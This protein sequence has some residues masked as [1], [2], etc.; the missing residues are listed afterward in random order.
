MIQSWSSVAFV[1]WRV[2]PDLIRPLVPSAFEVD[3]W[4]GSAWVGLVPFRMMTRAPFLPPVPV[5]SWFPETNVRT[6]VRDGLGRRGVWFLS[7]D[8]PRSAMVAVA[9]SALGL[10]YAWSRMSIEENELGAT[11][12]LARIA[13]NVGA[14]S[15]VI[16]PSRPSRPD[17]TALARFLTARFRLFGTGPLGPYLIPIEHRPWQLRRLPTATIEDELVGLTG[18]PRLGEPD[19]I[20]TSAGVHVRVGF[21]RLLE[22]SAVVAEADP[23]SPPT[24]V[25][26]AGVGSA[27]QVP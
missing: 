5:L 21:P 13:P 15:T 9:R 8:V 27:S 25:P 24:R 4:A 2:D 16:V 19:H 17:D 23:G 1:H 6:Y 22:P 12:L 18:L 3:T 11:Y 26:D 7:L 10:P 14:R 20:T